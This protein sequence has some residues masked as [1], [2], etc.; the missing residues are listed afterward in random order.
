M[1]LAALFIWQGDRFL[2]A[3]ND[4]DCKRPQAIVVLAGSTREEDPGRVKEGAVVFEEKGSDYLIFP[5]RH[6]RINWSWLVEKYHIKT[7]VP[8]ERV[9]IGRASVADRKINQE[10]G[11]TFTEA[12]MTIRIMSEKEIRSALVVTSGYHIRRARLAFARAK[13]GQGTTFCFHAVGRPNDKIPWWL[14]KDYLFRVLGEYKKLVGSY[15]L[16]R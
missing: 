15:F 2:S 9:L 12:E 13:K 3:T 7:K 8:K 6:P 11:G 5:L 4:G 14:D 1:A 10:L 16:Y